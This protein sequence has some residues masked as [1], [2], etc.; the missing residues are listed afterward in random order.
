VTLLL[1][2]VCYLIG[3]IPFSFLIARAFGVADVRKVGSGNVGATNVLRAAGK[4]AG[5]LAL[6]LDAAKGACATLLARHQASDPLLESLGA[7]AACIG[8]MWPVWL[9][10]RGGKG[11]ATG[12]G[13]FLPLAPAASGLALVVF[14]AC[15][16]V[17]RYVSLGSV[18]GALALPLFAGL[19]GAP[20][21]VFWTGLAL[22]GLIAFR[23]RANLERIAKGTERRLGRG[24]SAP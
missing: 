16:A 9:G 17:T 6:C 1:L 5:L 3:S 21:P 19:L 23:H 11:V 22:A 12:V 20:R 13:A 8:H 10:F 15:L 14:A 24:P 4:G 2:A 18:I 7:A